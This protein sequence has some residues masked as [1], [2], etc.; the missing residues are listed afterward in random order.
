MTTTTIRI[1]GMSCEHCTAAVATALRAVPGVADVRVELAA[2][3]A[4]LTLNAPVADEILTAAI[5]DVG[6]EVAGIKRGDGPA[7]DRA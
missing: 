1:E 7:P 3:R 2:G 4:L 5:T 6:F